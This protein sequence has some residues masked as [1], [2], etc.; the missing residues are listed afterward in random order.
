MRTNVLGTSFGFVR[1]HS[2]DGFNVS[3]HNVI[4]AIVAGAYVDRG[5]VL[6]FFRVHHRRRYVRHHQ[7]GHG[8]MMLIIVT[9]R[10]R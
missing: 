9:D 4:V 8:R 7:T 10:W 6:M 1:A 5:G 3:Q 2:G